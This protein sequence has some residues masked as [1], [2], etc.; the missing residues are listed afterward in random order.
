MFR[1]VER[2]HS[3]GLPLLFLQ[4]GLDLR[5]PFLGPGERFLDVVVAAKLDPD[6]HAVNQKSSDNQ[7]AHGLSISVCGPATPGF[8]L[9]SNLRTKSDSLLVFTVTRRRAVSMRLER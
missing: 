8:D 7:H 2:K 3:G 1:R 6:S 9:R 4:P 5:D